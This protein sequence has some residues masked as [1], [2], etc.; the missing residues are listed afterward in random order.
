MGKACQNSDAK[1]A[2]ALL[3]VRPDIPW[4]W[5]HKFTPTCS[6]SETAALFTADLATMYAG[7]I[8][9]DWGKI[10]SI[11]FGSVLVLVLILWTFL[12]LRKAHVPT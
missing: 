3:A 6:F 12:K 10:L 1:D 8:G 5:F 2:K 7:N 4:D 11:A 9:L